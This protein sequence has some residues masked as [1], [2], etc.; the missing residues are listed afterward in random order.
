MKYSSLL[1]QQLHNFFTECTVELA[2]SLKAIF[3]P[4]SERLHEW[5]FLLENLWETVRILTA[6]ENGDVTIYTEVA[7]RRCVKKIL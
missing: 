1:T 5:I 3:S 7:F 4:T 2:L 6:M